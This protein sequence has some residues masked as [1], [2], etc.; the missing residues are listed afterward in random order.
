M[1]NL[2]ANANEAAVHEAAID[3]LASEMHRPV[4][5]VKPHYER[6]V[7]RLLEGARVRDFLSVCAIRH[8][9]EALRGA[10]R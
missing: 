2:Y 3:A 1:G 5:E 6:E 8:T 10:A 4:D 7:S 9:K